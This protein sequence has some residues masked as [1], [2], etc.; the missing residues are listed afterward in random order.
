M[1]ISESSSLA[2]ALMHFANPERNEEFA[3]GLS[4]III[5]SIWSRFETTFAPCAINR[6]VKLFLAQC[7]LR[8]CMLP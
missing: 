3:D 1:C 2:A 6:I 7:V 5:L 4:I 8:E